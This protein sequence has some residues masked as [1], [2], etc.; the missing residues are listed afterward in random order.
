[1]LKTFNCGIGLILVV[2][3]ELVN[4][5]QT[6]LNEQFLESNQIGHIVEYNPEKLI[7]IFKK[8]FKYI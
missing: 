4:E 2:S 5:I 8:F 7:G 3:L 1:M 6:F